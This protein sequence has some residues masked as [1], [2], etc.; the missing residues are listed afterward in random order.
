MT[1]NFE[2]NFNEGTINF[3]IPK[4]EINYKNGKYISIFNHENKRGYIKI[5]KDKDN[6]LKFY[7]FYIGNGKCFLNTNIDGLDKNKKHMITFTWSLSDRKIDLYID[8]ELEN[9]CE[10]DVT[11]P[12]FSQCK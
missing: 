9:S 5:Q 2:I 4:G 6:G 11:P 8:G 10:I 12:Q 1:N 3:W 7:Y